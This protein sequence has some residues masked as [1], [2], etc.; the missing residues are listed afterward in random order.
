MK[1]TGKILAAVFLTAAA[2]TAAVIVP[3]ALMYRM[4]DAYIR[5]MFTEEKT[6]G[7]FTEYDI[8]DDGMQ[9]VENAYFPSAYRKIT[10]CTRNSR[11]R[12]PCCTAGNLRLRIS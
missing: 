8:T 5:P 3:R 1:K 9:K 12:A 6:G 10:L 4:A 2:V 7:Y 11:R